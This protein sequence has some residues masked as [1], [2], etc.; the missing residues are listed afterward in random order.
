MQTLRALTGNSMAERQ[1]SDS[2]PE[3]KYDLSGEISLIDSS[4]ESAPIERVRS[5][6]NLTKEAVH[7]ISITGLETISE[8]AVFMGV[9]GSRG[10]LVN[11]FSHIDAA[12]WTE[13]DLPENMIDAAYD[14][15]EELTR[16]EAGNFYHS[17]KYLPDLERR[18]IMAYYAFCRRADDIADGDYIDYFPGG[19]SERTESIYYRTKIERLIDSSP[20]V[21]RS[22]YNDKMSQ[23]FYF[24]KKLM[25]I[26][27]CS[28]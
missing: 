15:C 4:I 13:N 27:N 17:F 7:A 24:R 3:V 10:E 12:I 5:A 20:V 14:F 9:I 28:F 25:K 2:E 6:V 22:S 8:G 1:M 11:P 18:A 21:E 26:F 16:R 23:L 19:S